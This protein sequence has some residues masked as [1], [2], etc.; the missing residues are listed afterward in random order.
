MQP[1]E[2]GLSRSVLVLRAGFA[3]SQLST[4][5][6]WLGYLELTGTLSEFELTD[7]LR[8]GRDEV[9][10]GEHDLV[11][12][13]LNEHFDDLGLGSLVLYAEDLHQPLPP[14]R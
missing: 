10:P 6:L 8:G 4:S 5:Q 11:A 13:V 12:H 9:L 7:L 1:T 3:L 2:G 14:A